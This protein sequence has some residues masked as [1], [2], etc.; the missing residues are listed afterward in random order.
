MKKE[1]WIAYVQM[2]KKSKCA[3]AVFVTTYYVLKEKPMK[4]L[5]HF[6]M[7]IVLSSFLTHKNLDFIFIFVFTFSFITHVSTSNQDRGKNP[8]LCEKEIISYSNSNYDMKLWQNQ[9]L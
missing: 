7:R 1:I 4:S 5:D 2:S 3:L 6:Q 9:R 8:I